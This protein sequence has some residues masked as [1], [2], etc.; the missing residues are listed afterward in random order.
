MLM[1]DRPLELILIGGSLRSQSVNAAVIATAATLIPSGVRAAIFRRMGEL[2]HFNPDDDRD[3]LPEPV[4]DL[5]TQLETADGVL[6]STPE[7]AGSLPGSFKNLLDWT[8]GGAGLYEVPV[9]W[10]NPSSHGGSQE[11]YE[12]LRTVLDRAG[13]RIIASACVDVRVPRDAV[14]ADGLVAAPEARNAIGEA[15]MEL[16]KAAKNRPLTRALRGS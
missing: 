8:I 4:A 15:V 14:G 11:A 12:D 2:P 3:P 6:L 10:I 5:R 1:T 7:Y 13:A 9:G 16:L